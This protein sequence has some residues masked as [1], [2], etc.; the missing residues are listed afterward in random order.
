[1][2]I[3]ILITLTFIFTVLFSSA[4]AQKLIK[5][6]S[7]EA[8]TIVEAL[9]KSKNGDTVIV[10]PGLYKE[11]F[12]LPSGITLMAEKAGSVVIDGKGRGNTITLQNSSSLVGIDVTNG[13]AGIVTKSPGISII[14]C[15]IYRNSGSA[16][17]CTGNLPE[18]NNCLIVFN[19]GSGIQAVNISGG[20]TIL[21][22]NT[23]AYNQNVGISIS[24]K[25]GI[26]IKNN[27]ISNN[28]SQGIK[29]DGVSEN[30]CKINN[31]VFYK[32]HRSKIDLPKN[33]IETDP[34]FREPKRK[35]MDFSLLPNSPAKGKASDGTDPG[36]ST[37]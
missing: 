22:R 19:Q 10:A 4:S 25:T 7:P 27:I 16:I 18:I 5:V 13:T 37:N 1:M 23:V 11:Q 15:R 36:F 30:L 31:N 29:L 34:Q 9:Q 28:T 8:K 35:V 12:T 24:G 21:E 32:N 20:S 33:N 17:L 3:K 6:P 2:Q 26:T 14:N